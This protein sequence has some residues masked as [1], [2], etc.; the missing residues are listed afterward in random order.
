M[1]FL[2]RTSVPLLKLLIE[3]AQLGNAPNL[4]RSVKANVISL[5]DRLRQDG[6]SHEADLILGCVSGVFLLELNLLDNVN[7]EEIEA[8]WKSLQKPKEVCIYFLN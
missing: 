7:P 4:R 5:H 6:F 2:F 8:A 1:I 3:T